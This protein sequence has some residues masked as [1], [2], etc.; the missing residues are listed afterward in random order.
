MAIAPN[1]PRHPDLT[2]SDILSPQTWPRRGLKAPVNELPSNSERDP[3]P[4]M[5]DEGPKERAKKPIRPAAAARKPAAKSRLAEMEEPAVEAAESS[6]AE[7]L[8]VVATE[9]PPWE[10][11]FEEPLGEVWEED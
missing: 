7:P 2:A 9:E 11:R 1:D 5:F 8:P 10:P 3:A 4:L 6:M